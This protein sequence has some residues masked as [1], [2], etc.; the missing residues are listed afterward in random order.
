MKL[1]ICKICKQEYTPQRQAQPRCFS[2]IKQSEKDKR[3]T[4]LKKQIEKPLKQNPLKIKIDERQK[5]VNAFVR[6][7]DKGK[8]CISCGIMGVKLEAGHYIS[9]ARSSKMRYDL[10]NIH[11][12]CWNCNNILHGNHEGFKKGLIERYGKEYLEN[13]DNKLLKENEILVKK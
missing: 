5:E 12:Q 2:C 13:L 4:Q 1:H 7:R 9:R 3:F 10:D 8:P 6:Q 11:G